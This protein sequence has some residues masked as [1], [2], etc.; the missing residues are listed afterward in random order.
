MIK[1]RDLDERSSLT[2]RSYTEYQE[3]TDFRLKYRN[4]EELIERVV[5]HLDAHP[6]NLTEKYE[7][8][9]A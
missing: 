8:K 2:P 6:V 3:K 9:K 5:A 7:T 1:V 4:Q